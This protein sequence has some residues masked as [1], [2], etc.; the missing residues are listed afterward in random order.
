MEVRLIDH[1]GSDLS[2]VNAARV[3]FAQHP[4]QRFLQRKHGQ[5]LPLINHCPCGQQVLLSLIVSFRK[6]AALRT[7]PFRP[8]WLA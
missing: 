2:L 1:M 6:V 4:T 3:S 5:R 7:I 8:G